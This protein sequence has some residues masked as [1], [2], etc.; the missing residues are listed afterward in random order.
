[1]SRT[2]SAV[3]AVA[4]LFGA[5]GL[6]QARENAPANAPTCNPRAGKAS[7]KI[8]CLTTIVNSLNREISDLRDE[9]N[10]RAMRTDFSA[11]LRRSELDDALTDY[12]R[13]KSPLAINL[14]LEPKNDQEDGRCLAADAGQES[15]VAQ[16]PCSFD[17]KP[18]LKWRLLRDERVSSTSR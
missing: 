11:Y 18:Q 10:K 4:M 16:K 15:V 1:M 9:L 6:L 3:V 13:Y 14:A 5:R 12:V 17:T 8:E 7:A 2:L